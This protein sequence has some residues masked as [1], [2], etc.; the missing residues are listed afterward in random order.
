MRVML[1]LVYIYTGREI[2]FKQCTNKQ[3]FKIISEKKTYQKQC[4]GNGG[5]NGAPESHTHMHAHAQWGPVVVVLILV[6]VV[7]DDV[8]WIPFKER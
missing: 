3:K 8:Q 4:N 1:M 2:Q 7:V 5:F 6:V